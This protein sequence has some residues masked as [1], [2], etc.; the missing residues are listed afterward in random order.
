MHL[1]F[2]R[3]F[4]FSKCYLLVEIAVNPDSVL[5]TPSVRWNDVG[6]HPGWD[7]SSS[8]GAMHT[9]TYIYTHSHIGAI[10]ETH[11]ETPLSE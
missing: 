4:I 2:I 1:P 11:V 10:L 8:K 7:V 6:M 3:L 9:H 5:G